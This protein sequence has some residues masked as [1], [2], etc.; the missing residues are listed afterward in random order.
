MKSDSVNSLMTRHRQVEAGR[1]VLVGIL[2]LLF[3]RGLLPLQVLLAAVAVGVYPLVKTGVLDLVHERKIGTE[4]FVTVAT[5]I[6]V[7]AGE[8]VA[9]SVLMTIILILPRLSRPSTP[10]QSGRAISSLPYTA[11]TRSARSRAGRA[12]AS[13][14]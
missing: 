2:T 11:A 13:G 1:I 5:A 4:I 10:W 6:A 14:R 3:W 7:L 8:Y 9:A 12:H